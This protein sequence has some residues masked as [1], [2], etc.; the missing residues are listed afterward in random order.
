[1][2]SLDKMIRE[3]KEL[4]PMPAVANRLLEMV[5]EPD[6]SMNDIAQIIQYD[7]VMTVDILKVCNSAYSGL[8]M[9]AESIKDAVNMLG[10]DQIIELAMVKS[11]AKILSGR[12]KGYGL[13]Q[14]DM[15]RY[16]VSS[17]VIAKQVA[18]R[19][20][21]NNKSTIFTAALI[22][23]IGKIILEKYVFKDFKK[24]NTLVKKFGY[25]F[26]ESEKK[27]LGIDHAE[28]G[29]LIGKI[30]KFSPRMIKLIQHHHLR[31]ESMIN[32]KEVAAVYLSDCICMMMGDGVGADGLAY[33]FKDELMKIHSVSQSD[34]TGIMAEFAVNMHE[35]NVLL[36]M[37]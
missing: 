32:D 25:S 12:R 7:P 6:S 1:M 37:A 34:I 23:D 2:T 26:R 13:E 4:T 29:A 8:K 16:S 24:I 28:M 31:D 19:L 17:A 3:I 27:V 35:V 20:G 14:G 33:R 30:W 11:S 10:T 22:K 15:W 21:L 9:P 36:N 18:I 5:E